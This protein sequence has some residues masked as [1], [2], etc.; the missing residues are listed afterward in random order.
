MNCGR[1]RPLTLIALT[2]SLA[3]SAS[4]Q[5][6]DCGRCHARQA[7]QSKTGMAR[8]L[9]APAKEEI[10]R[11]HPLL[12][13]RQG[14]YSYSIERRG[15]ESIYS[16]TDGKDTIS[17][18]ISW[19]F[20]LGAAGQT[21][22]LHRNGLWYEGRVSY[23]KDTQ[24]LDLTVGAQPNAPPNLDEA[25]GRELSPQGAEECFN[26]HSTGA[27]VNG[28]LTVDHLTP[29]VQCARCHEG[30]ERHAAKLEDIPRKLHAMTSE[31]T[32]DYCGQCH[33]TWATIA[34]QGPNNITN[35]RFQPYRLVNSKCYDAADDRIRCTSCHDPHN[36]EAKPFASYDNRC[37]ACHAPGG[38]GKAGAK[39]CSV[40]KANCAGC[41]M[42][43]VLIPT[44]HN[45]F[46]DHWIR[47]DKP[48]TPPPV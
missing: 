12:T 4:A 24:A 43:K 13:F 17:L 28:K 3:V 37:Q 32:A 39:L 14:P 47:I 48:G 44:A 22:L 5:N 33:R 18:P 38:K 42:P 9:S 21:Y 7:P 34:T 11:S 35:V 16:V 26:C 36:D 41:H 19:A 25:L 15:D 6:D 30:V 45:R 2:A 31:E 8:A 1:L 40:G 23:Y 29:G 10:L 20:G 27:V 46:T